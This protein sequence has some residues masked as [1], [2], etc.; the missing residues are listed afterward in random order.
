MKTTIILLVLGGLLFIS[1]NTLTTTKTE[2]QN[3]QVLKKYK[4]FEVRMYP[5]AVFASV[6]KQGE[7]MDIGN[8]GFRDLAG[9]IF[10]DN[11]EGNKIAMTAPVYINP[12][13]E[14]KNKSEMSFV[15]PQEYSLNNLPQPKN[16]SI[17]LWKSDSVVV[18][19]LTFG[20]FANNKDIAKKQEELKALILESK[21]QHKN[22][23]KYMSYNPP[24]QLVNRRN[25][26]SVDLVNF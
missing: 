8:Q 10:G 11:Q 16:S 12:D 22:N 4:G 5:P 6:T 7:M 25:E 2:M 21:L 13:K 26:V 15:M 24:Y 1:W 3:Y 14:D 19:V 9:Y 20:G 23:F 18:A 17:K